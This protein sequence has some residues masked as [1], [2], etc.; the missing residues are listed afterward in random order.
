MAETRTNLLQPTQTTNP[1]RTYACAIF[2]NHVSIRNTRTYP[3]GTHARV[4]S[5]A[6]VR[7]SAGATRGTVHHRPLLAA[8]SLTVGRAMAN[9]VGR[10]RAA[11]TKEFIN[12]GAN[13]PAYAG[14]RAECRHC[15]TIMAWSMTVFKKHQRICPAFPRGLG[16]LDP[17]PIPPPPP[18]DTSPD[19]T[20]TMQA[21]ASQSQSSVHSIRS[22]V[23]SVPGSRTPRWCDSMSKAEKETADKLLARAIHRGANSFS[24]LNSKHWTAFIRYLR[25][26]YSLPSRF[27]LGGQLLD[28]EY[29]SVQY[30]T[31]AAIE[32]FPT[33]CLTLDGATNNAGK[34]VLN[35]MACGPCAFFLEQVS[36]SWCYL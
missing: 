10:P 29:K 21:Q 8:K 2:C 5:F 36:R 19:S 1:F 24:Q 12:L 31:I 34:Q 20:N 35:M 25:P 3:F 16:Q 17:G 30:E 9:R 18:Q 27:A 33:I 26:A 11:L 15:H 28:D 6:T 14:E 7:T 13:D 32:T 23:S 4:R 22:I